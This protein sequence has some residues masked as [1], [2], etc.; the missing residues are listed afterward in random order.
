MTSSIRDLNDYD[1]VKKCYKCKMICLKNNFPK[2]ES[3]IMVYT[4]SVNSVDNSIMM[5]IENK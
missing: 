4:N 3:R 2:G 1:L 5:K